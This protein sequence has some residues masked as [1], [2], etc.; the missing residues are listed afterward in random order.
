[1]GTGS[2]LLFNI[3]SFIFAALTII[4]LVLI[5]GIMS[6]AMTPPFF[7][8]EPTTIPPTSVLDLGITPTRPFIPT[9][10]PSNTPDWTSTP[11]E[12][13][14]PTATDTE[15]PTPTVTNTSAPRPTFTPSPVDAS[16]EAPVA[17]APIAEAPTTSFTPEPSGAEPSATPTDSP[18]RFILQPG[19]PTVRDNF[20]NGLACAWQGVGGQV[21]DQNGDPV[22][23]VQIRVMDASGNAQYTISGT[24]SAYGPSGWEIGLGTQPASAT[25]TVQLWSANQGEMSP[26]V[27]IVFPGTCDQNLGLVNFVRTR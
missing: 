15:M 27:E 21:V 1:M 6:D 2:N 12:T 3:I 22:I 7:A 16:V 11:T 26:S 8:P 20:A 14:Q 9:F 24:N 4:V 25:Y 5:I 10:T 13:P 23:G 17:E 19:T 18:Y